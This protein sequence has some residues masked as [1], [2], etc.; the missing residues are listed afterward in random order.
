MSKTARNPITNDL[1]KSKNSNETFD[2]NFDQIDWS[3]KL[4]PAKKEDIERII[5][6][7]I[8]DHGDFLRELKD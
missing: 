3:V 6:E 7:V 8:A 4:E 2:K 1:I 5:E